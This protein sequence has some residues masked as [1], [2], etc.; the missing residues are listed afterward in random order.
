MRLHARRSSVRSSTG[1]AFLTPSARLVPIIALLRLAAGVLLLVRPEIMAR[2]LGVDRVTARRTAWL[3]T[4][5][6]GRELGLGLG[7]LEADRHDDGRAA[8][9]V[10]A[11]AVADAGDAV[12]FLSAAVRGQVRVP[13]A[14]AMA[15]ISIATVACESIMVRDLLANRR[16]VED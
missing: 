1:A 2:A 15:A 5:V 9:W 3:G 4:L 10:A 11:Q 13:R 16:A 7:A 6:A 8:S 12:A 14:V